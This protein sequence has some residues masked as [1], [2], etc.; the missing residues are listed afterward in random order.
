MQHQKHILNN[1]IIY[2]PNGKIKRTFQLE[3]Y[4]KLP[5]QWDSRWRPM[6]PIGGSV[7]THLSH[8][9]LLKSWWAD[10]KHAQIISSNNI[11]QAI[12]TAGKKPCV[13]S[14][15][16]YKKSVQ[17]GCSWGDS[18]EMSRQ[19]HFCSRCSLALTERSL[20]TSSDV[21]TK[22]EGEKKK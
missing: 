18:S 22:K 12:T 15:L 16:M 10:H 9:V 20:K 1:A 5:G 8:H 17:A 6:W 3:I 7:F 11:S 21:A 4:I 19:Q 14:M 13:C 2:A